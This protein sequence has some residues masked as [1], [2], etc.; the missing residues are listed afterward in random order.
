MKKLVL[1]CLFAA[2]LTVSLFAQDRPMGY[3]D[4]YKFTHNMLATAINS[5]GEALEGGEV[6]TRAGGFQSLGTLGG[7]TSGY[8]INDSGQVA[9]ASTVPSGTFHAFL[10]S[11]RGGMQDLGSLLGGDT[12]ATAINASGQVAGVSYSPDFGTTHAFFWSA[13]TGLVD[14]GTLNG[15]AFSSVKGLNA[16]GEIAGISRPTPGSQGNTAFRWTMAGGIQALLGFG[17]D[18]V[19]NGIN[20]SGQIAGYS[21]YPDGTQHAALWAA[22]GSVQ[23]LGT[24]LGD[25]TSSA[26]FLNGAGHIA[27]YSGYKLHKNRGAVNRTFFWTP[28][29]GMIDL[30]VGTGPLYVPHALNQRDQV[31]A[32]AASTYIWSPTLRAQAVAGGVL[33]PTGAFNDAG[34]FSGRLNTNGNEYLLNPVM[35]VALTSSQNPSHAGQSVTFTANVSSIV[36]LPPDGEQVAFKDGSKTLGTGTLSSGVASFATS[37]LKVGTHNI[38]A[39][40]AGDGNYFPNKSAKLS[41]VVTQ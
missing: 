12:Y 32:H 39:V 21:T 28:E 9:G 25:T 14:V 6:W 20:D 5:S 40:Y 19:P 16:H 23:D 41:Q 15:D 11:P 7:T 24:L 4:N 27:G 31:L 35:H 17:G 36:A 13:G 22:N 30:M 18:S 2:V 29:G 38:T 3:G 34:V 37:T 26:L 8:A 33:T 1:F 10:W